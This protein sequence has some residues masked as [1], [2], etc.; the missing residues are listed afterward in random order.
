MTN[1]GQKGK[2]ED[3]VAAYCKQRKNVCVKRGG[4]L[5]EAFWSFDHIMLSK[6]YNNPM[7]HR[8]FAKHLIFSADSYFECVVEGVGFYCNGV[9]IDSNI[10]HTVNHDSGDLLVFLFDET[11]NLAAELDEKYLKGK[12][13]C[14]IHAELSLKVSEQWKN[15]YDDAKK[16]DEAILSAC[17]IKNDISARYDDRICQ[18]LERISKMEGIYEDTIGMLCDAVYLSRSRVSHLFKK[19]VGVSLSNY[20]VFEKMRKAYTYIAAGEN[21]TAASIRAGFSSSSHFSNVCRKMFGLAFTDVIKTAVFK[22][23]I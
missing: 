15:N 5:K 8:H 22:E 4:N 10:E 18:I 7:P 13:F 3:W 20:L 17:N 12:P 23:I 2:A 1:C 14:L 21:I 19:Q 9:C 6:S 16:L 11:S